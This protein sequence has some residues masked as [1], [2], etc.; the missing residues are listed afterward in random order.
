M[1]TQWLRRGWLLAACASALLAACGGGSIVSQLSP[2]RIVAFGDA[3][4][5]LGQTGARY[6]V[7]DSTVN[8]WT[9]FVASAFGLP[10]APTSA[11]GNSY[12][13]GNA[14]VTAKPDA[15]G[16]SSTRTVTEQIDAF[17]A[18]GRPVETDLFLVS[19]GTSDVIVQAQA[20]ITGTQTQDQ[21]LAA[22][23]QAGRELAAQ[24]RRLVNA[25]ASHVV[26][27]GPYN[28]GRSPWAVQLSQ[29]SL[30]EAA[31]SRFNEQL[32]VSLVDLG[33]KVLYVDAALYF[34]LLTAN[35]GSN[36][37]TNSNSPVCTSIDSGPG[38]GTGSGQVNSLLCTP[39]TIVT[40]VDYN[41]AL[42][43]D[44]VYPTPRVHQLFGDYARSRIR[45]RW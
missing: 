44:R 15:A 35:P 22:V 31:S 21:M 29:Q 40:G 37:L 16:N 5:D 26:V 42:F 45:E 33:E 32:L 10:L 36:S 12:A 3:M 13:T 7:N 23:G 17:L 28:L 8:N 34:N 41:A 2:T 4:A 6:T 38:I 39:S 11:G 30:L 14:R 24:V 1:A 27:A 20:V 19:A 18:A 9:Q 25:G 43:A